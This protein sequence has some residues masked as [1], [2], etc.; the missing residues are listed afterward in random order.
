MAKGEDTRHHPSRKVGR[1]DLE[2]TTSAMFG[3]MDDLKAQLVA[4]GRY[5]P[6]WDEPEEDDEDAMEAS[7][8]ARENDGLKPDSG[9]SEREMRD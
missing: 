4:Q 3:A 7:E 1:A 6:A 8:D 5:N 9:F 2:N